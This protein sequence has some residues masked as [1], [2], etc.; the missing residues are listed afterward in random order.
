MVDYSPEKAA[1]CHW[2]DRAW[3]QVTVDGYGDLD[4]AVAHLL[5]H[6]SEGCAV[7]DE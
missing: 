6:V 3:N 5:L 2:V 1:L 4:R 7:L